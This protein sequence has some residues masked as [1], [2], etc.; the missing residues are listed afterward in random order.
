MEQFLAIGNDVKPVKLVTTG[1]HQVL[2][3]KDDIIDYGGSTYV[4]Y[5]RKFV[6]EDAHNGGSLMGAGVKSVTYFCDL[7]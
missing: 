2:H 7:Y 1:K 3:Q 4:V 5:K 6:Y